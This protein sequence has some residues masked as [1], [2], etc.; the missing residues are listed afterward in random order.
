MIE[1][2]AD[3]ASRIVCSNDTGS[4]STR[5]FLSL[6]FVS[7]LTSTRLSRRSQG[8]AGFSYRFLTVPPLWLLSSS[9]NEDWKMKDLHR[10]RSRCTRGAVRYRRRTE[11]ISRLSHRIANQRGH[12]MHVLTTR[13]A[14]NHGSIVVED[15][16]VAG[17]GQ[18]K[19][20]A[21][22]AWTKTP[23]C[24]RRNG[25]VAPTARVQVRLVRVGTCACRLISSFIRAVQCLQAG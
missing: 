3:C 12:A 10:A 18:A 14:K 5:L 11:A 2:S 23:A 21:R 24:R 4:S 7:S 8:V 20:P 19:A 22:C 16:N 1:T 6:S 13:L 25:G 9:L 15:L 17:Y